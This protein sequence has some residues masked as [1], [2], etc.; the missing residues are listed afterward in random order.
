MKPGRWP[1]IAVLLAAGVLAG[2]TASDQE[3][4]FLSRRAYMQRQNQGTRE[5]IAEAEQG[6]LVPTDRFL[7][8]IDEKVIGEVFRYQLPMERPLGKRFVVHLDSAT[9]SLRDKFGLIILEGEIHRP[10]SPER[11]TR[12][13]IYGGLGGIAVDSTSRQLNVNI[14]IDR[15][16]LREAGLLDRVLGAG[17]K[18]FL[19]EKGLQA[20]QDALP[21]F[22]IPVALAQNI[23][24]P[25][26]EEGPIALDSLVVPL[27][28]SVERVLAA[29]GKLW[30]TLDATVGKVTGAEEGLGVSVKKKPRKPQPKTGSGS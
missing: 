20:L 12:V 7:I 6:S 27:D 3:T 9:I 30:V 8:G 15:I 28:M 26:F 21:T 22:H 5:L 18:K 14:A 23:R 1:A 17:G 29:G 24:V 4:E 13:R 16:E 10:Q 25:A 19:A 11:K 2:C